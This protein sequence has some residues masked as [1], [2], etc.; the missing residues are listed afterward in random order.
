M[1]LV[2]LV[3]WGAAVLVSRPQNWPINKVEVI[4]VANQ[5]DRL[6]VQ[7]QLKG[8]GEEGFFSL[9]LPQWQS[10]LESVPWVAGAQL[11]RV[12]PDHVRVQISTRQ[13]AA[14]WGEKQL[15]DISGKIFS[16]G[17]QGLPTESGIID[18]LMSVDA[19]ALFA[20]SS[21]LLASERLLLKSLLSQRG[22]VEI[23]LTNGLLLKAGN[24][25]QTENRLRRMVGVYKEHLSPV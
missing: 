23:E 24:L 7:K 16:P 5:Q 13:P 25:L 4:G 20:A 12:W 14:R 19:L 10:R 2:F 11:Q 6:Q 21:E 17:G 1:L 3:L 18:A 9:N 15:I 8:I 22:S